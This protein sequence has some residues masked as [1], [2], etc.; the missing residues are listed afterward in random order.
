M[1]VIHAMCKVVGVGVPVAHL[2]CT[3]MVVIGINA[4]TI[5]PNITHSTINEDHYAH[6]C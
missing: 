6:E 2:F 1:M 5:T 3:S 4:L